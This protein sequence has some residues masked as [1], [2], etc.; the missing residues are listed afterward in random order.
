MGDRLRSSLKKQSILTKKRNSEVTRNV[1]VIDVSE[2]LAKLQPSQQLVD[3]YREKV[4]KLETQHN[5]V[6]QLLERYKKAS[7]PTFEESERQDMTC[8]LIELRSALSDINIFMHAERQQVTRVHAENEQLQ[9]ALLEAEK[10]VLLLLTLSG[11][12]EGELKVFMRDP[13]H[14]HI[15]KQR[16]PPHLRALHKKLRKDLP[17]PTPGQPVESD[18]ELRLKAEMK[19]LKRQLQE[20]ERNWHKEKDVLLQDRTLKASES[21]LQASKDEAH[22]KLL[23][24]RLEESQNLVAETT[25][26]S[27]KLRCKMQEQEMKWLAEKDHLLSVLAS[28]QDNMS[29]TSHLEAIDRSGSYTDLTKVKSTCELKDLR[30]DNEL[31]KVEA[32][33]AEDLRVVYEA[34][35]L[36]LE[37]RMCKLREE[38]EATEQMFKERNQKLLKQVDM[39]RNENMKLNERRKTDIRGFQT[40][41]RL[42]KDDMKTVVHQIYKLT[43]ALSGDTIPVD[44]ATLNEMQAVTTLVR[45]VQNA[46]EAQ[47]RALLVGE[48]NIAYSAEI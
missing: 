46:I 15:V 35:C 21:K 14:T 9:L 22:I 41:I 18:A 17:Q 8:E 47:R 4:T 10:K 44:F 24:A 12:T 19:S 20:S 42:L 5:D 2:E 28:V 32:A 7:R 13:R 33:E 23:I 11:L 16:L 48:S 36:Q 37:Q 38:K 31:L 27:I 29:L 39:L 1:N 43:M 30:R 3:F 6:L 34:Q 45:A 40:S 25:E 26:D